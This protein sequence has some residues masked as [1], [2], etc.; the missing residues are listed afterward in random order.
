MV[1][2]SYSRT[3]RGQNKDPTRVYPSGYFVNRFVL[4]PIE[5]QRRRDAE[6]EIARECA[7]ETLRLCASAVHTRLSNSARLWPEPRIR[8]KALG[9]V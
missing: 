9:L 4:V 2:A 8:S 5:P 3:P 7:P 6:E 1:I